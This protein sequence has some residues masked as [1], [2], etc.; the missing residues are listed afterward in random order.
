MSMENRENTKDGVSQFS[1]EC[2]QLLEHH[3][4]QLRASGISVEVIKERGYESVTDAKRL[5]ELGFSSNQMSLPG[6]LMP[7]QGV[8]GT[9]VGYQYRP[10]YPRTRKGK[11]AK[12]ESPLGQPNRIDTNPLCRD[13]LADPHIECWIVEGI[14]KEDALVSA[15]EV[16]TGLT[17]VWNW[18]GKNAFG[19]KT[20]LA[21][22]ELIAWNDRTV[23]LAF[24]SDWRQNPQVRQAVERL[25]SHLRR[26]GAVVYI[27]DIPPGQNGEKQGVDDFLSS[28][29]SVEDLKALA[30]ASTEDEKESRELFG[31]HFTYQDRLYL[32][33]RK[34]DGGYAFA[35]L[36]GDNVKLTLE[37]AVDDKVLKPLPLPEVE[38]RVLEIVGLPTED[39]VHA[40]LC[41]PDE[42]YARVKNHV[43]K[44]VDLSPLDVEL[45]TYYPLFSCF[46]LKVNTVGYLRYL[47]DTGKGKTRAKKVVGDL[48]FYP[49]YASGASSFSGMARMQERWRGT[50]VIDEADF[51]GEKEAQLVKYLNL[52]FER[53]Q[54][55]IL[56]DKKNPRFQDYFDPFGP[57]VLAM[58]E[59]FRDNA[60]EGRLLSITMHETQNLDLPI[61]LPKEYDSE[62]RQLRNELI[63]FTLHNWNKVDGTRM[64]SFADLNIEPRLKQL[65]MP[66][67]I[68]FQLW[69]EGE[70]NFRQYLVARQAE[71]RRIR[72]MSWAGSLVNTVIAIATCD[73]ESDEEFAGYYGD[74]GKCVQAVTPSMVNRHIKSTAKSI[75][76]GLSNVGFVVEQRWIAW[77]KDGEGKRRRVRAYAVPD[78]RV[79]GEIM[80]RYYYS[81]DGNDVPDLPECLKSS[82]FVVCK[83]PSQPS[84]PSQ[85]AALDNK[86]PTSFGTHGT[87]GTL[88]RTPQM[89][90]TQLTKASAVD[91]RS[92]MLAVAQQHSWP[93]ITISQG[94]TVNAG[95][96][97]WQKFAASAPHEQ[98]E[99]ALATLGASE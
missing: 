96:E 90:D 19:G 8:D 27:V 24:D 99:M 48:C 5:R 11:P 62:M 52:G 68:I 54:Y 87:D 25:A 84:Q 63:L 74:D 44:Y 82:K 58:R 80:S 81:E 45:S 64:L 57:K 47:A 1:D 97:A 46:S 3:S 9:V 31:A 86:E 66:L 78:Y 35:Y 88:P 92:W 29:H 38:G 21:D 7:L 55:Y 91:S 49:V 89:D 2:P 79:W 17:G 4:S 75:T 42:L 98:L 56:S 37:V 41:S 13:R 50:L 6:I 20:S 14:K 34:H 10:D 40:R 22:F 61:I 93:R 16:A 51:A 26:Q 23:Y 30:V 12:Y 59:P 70:E 67:S 18:R 71:I 77:H 73:L 85:Q 32:E 94:V 53:W 83:E 39:I 15:G 28:G 95:E 76:K 43:A 60:T 36:E 69:P 65:A 33:V 72:S